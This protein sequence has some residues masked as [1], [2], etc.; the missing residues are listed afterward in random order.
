MKFLI[1][2][3]LQK[4]YNHIHNRYKINTIGQIIISQ[5]RNNYVI[6]V[7]RLNGEIIFNQTPGTI[8]YAKSIRKHIMT[9]KEVI[10][11]IIYRIQKE[12]KLKYFKLIFKGICKGKRI[13]IN[14]LMY[15]KIKIFTINSEIFYPHNGCRPKKQRR[16]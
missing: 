12:T 6:N 11:I 14:N 7:T 13:I 1:N 5:K 15:S 16:L 4:N 3:K 8:G 2:N 10:D 9:Y